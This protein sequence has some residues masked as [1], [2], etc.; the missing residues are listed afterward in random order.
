MA[1]WVI[2][3]CPLYKLVCLTAWLQMR[4]EAGC[5]QN[6]YN[7]KLQLSGLS[8]FCILQWSLWGAICHVLPC[9]FLLYE[10][11]YFFQFNRWSLWFAKTWNCDQ[12][13]HF[14]AD[15]LWAWYQRRRKKRYLSLIGL[16]MASLEL[17]KAP[18]IAL[19]SPPPPFFFFRANIMY[20][21]LE[22]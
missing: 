6:N 7:V 16:H 20:S 19:L 3:D 2:K 5:R 4:E 13:M 10:M 21:H 14:S 11:H 12:T 22:I 15:T 9:L 1:Y 8:D 18:L 17:P